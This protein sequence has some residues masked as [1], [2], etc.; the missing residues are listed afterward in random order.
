[1]SALRN[2]LGLLA[3]LGVLATGCGPARSTATPVPETGTPIAQAAGDTPLPPVATST[4]PAATETPIRPT[5]TPV[6]PTA[7]P[8]PPTPTTPPTLTPTAPPTPTVVATSG[9][10]RFAPRACRAPIPPGYEAT[11]G[12]LFV[13]EDRSQPDG[14]TVRMHVAIF[15]SQDP[16][17][18]P[19]PVIYLTGGGGVDTFTVLPW[20]LPAFGDAILEHR[21]LIFFN[22][23][24]MQR[25]DP[26]LKC[27]GFPE[28]LQRLAAPAADGAY[29]D[30]Q[31]RESQQ[32]AFFAACYESLVAQ[33]IKL[34][35]YD[36]VTSAADAN[37]LRIALGYDE[38]N[39]YGSSYGTLLGLLL[40]RDHPEGARS[41]VLDSVF[42]PEASYLNEYG[43]NAYD[44]FRLLFDGCIEDPECNEQ[45]P[46]LETKLLEAVDSLN[47]NPRTAT[48]EGVLD[49]MYNGEALIDVVY[50]YLYIGE[51]EIAIEA[52]EG[53][54][55]GDFSVADATAPSIMDLGSHY[56]QWGFYRNRDCREEAPFSSFEAYYAL[57]EGVPHQ[58][59]E[60]YKPSLVLGLCEGWKVEPA[61][62]IENEAVVSDVPVLVVSGELDPI[63]PPRW[64]RA[65]AEHLS[66][67][68]FYVFPGFSHGVTRKSPCALELMLRFFD[69][70]TREPDL[71]CLDDLIGPE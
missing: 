69:D 30:R 19:D 42:P 51:P 7:T 60:N 49:V 35:T 36:S 31:E 54:S 1:M 25:N 40:M 68:L 32:A 9:L 24:G 53:A 4:P 3:L 47:A 48:W 18:A 16:N 17:P 33:G 62:P 14:R 65:A 43:R 27:P 10:P 58:I 38:V 59:V 41:V 8:A 28:L 26:Q 15:H 64:A 20:F 71:P 34:E 37:D 5:A 55:A 44:T 57:M 23:R 61:D 11:C 13:P 39:Y 45:H 2:A 50:H 67:S 70:P 46:D 63:T 52:I 6:S 56:I 29:I 66:N 12:D 22:Q 21:D